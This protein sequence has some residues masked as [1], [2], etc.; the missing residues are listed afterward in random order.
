MQTHWEQ[1]MEGCGRSWGS[2]TGRRPAESRSACPSEEAGRGRE[3]PSP[4]PRVCP[5]PCA[6]GSVS[7]PVHRGRLTHSHTMSNCY[8]LDLNPGHDS[9]AQ[10]CPPCACQP[11]AGGGPSLWGTAFSD[12]L[13]PVIG[14]QGGLDGASEDAVGADTCSRTVLSTGS[15]GRLQV[16]GQGLLAGEVAAGEDRAVS[17]CLKSHTSWQLH[18]RSL[19]GLLTLQL[20]LILWF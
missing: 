6:V 15:K 13:I 14:T 10:A 20:W 2:G 4:E 3:Q 19:W 5:Q 17:L 11:G 18:C 7:L 8:I 12:T 16:E 1:G 9:R